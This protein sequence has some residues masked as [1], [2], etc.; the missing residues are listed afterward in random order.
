MA[1]FISIVY[2]GERSPLRMGILSRWY[3]TLLFKDRRNLEDLFFCHYLLI[4]LGLVL[5]VT[6][7]SA[8]VNRLACHPF[9][10]PWMQ[11]I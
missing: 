4:P 5:R 10:V 9:C 6:L 2:R 11:Q 7:L 1:V 8:L 3:R